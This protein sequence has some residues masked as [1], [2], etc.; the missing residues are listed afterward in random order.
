M[1]DFIY[2]NKQALKRTFSVIQYVPILALVLL[3]FHVAQSFVFRFLITSFPSVNFA[4]GFVRYIIEIMVASALLSALDDI[5]M[6]R[7]FSFDN[8]ING[9]TRYLSPLLNTIFFLYLIEI[10]AGM[11]AEFLGGVVIT[12]VTLLILVLKSPL[13]EQVYIANNS[14]IN[15]ITD[16]LEFIK[17]NIINWIIP[18]ILFVLLDF[19]FTINAEI[20]MFTLSAIVPAILFAFGLAFLY[21]YKGNLFKILFQSSR[22]KRQFEGMF[23]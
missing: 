3:F 20:L 14:G 11:F 10:V 4:M 21:I 23:D 16:S 12:I 8:L 15:A 13:Y 2:V 22:R 9:F 5:V 1:K 17:N 19:N 6:Y 18:T 7:R